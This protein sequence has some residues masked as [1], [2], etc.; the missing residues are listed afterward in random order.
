MSLFETESLRLASGAV[1][2]EGR[3][4]VFHNGVWGT[5]CSDRFTNQSAS[6]AC[7]MLGY[8]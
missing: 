2:G 1:A 6:V 8:G 4:E 5:V 3:L 7:D